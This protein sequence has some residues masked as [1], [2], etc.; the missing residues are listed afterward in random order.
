M[1]GTFFLFLFPFLLLL[2]LFCLLSPFYWFGEG[3]AEPRLAPLLGQ[4]AGAAAGAWRGRA[5]WP[6][7]VC[8]G[9]ACRPAGR[10]AGV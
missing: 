4:W 8:S 5:C 3:I 10:R 1:D 9:L 6:A 2:F 7:P